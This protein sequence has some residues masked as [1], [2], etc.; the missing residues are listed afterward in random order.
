MKRA[1]PHVVS[2][3]LLLTGIAACDRNSNN[4]DQA[5]GT[6]APPT[7][8]T[9]TEE[10]SSGAPDTTANTGGIS[11]P[12][13]PVHDDLTVP[14]ARRGALSASGADVC[15]QWNL[16]GDTLARCRKEW[17]DAQGDAERLRIR[18]TYEP[19]AGAKDAQEIPV[20]RQ[21]EDLNNPTF[22]DQFKLKDSDRSECRAQWKAAKTEGDLARIRSRYETL[23]TN[24][25][26]N[27]SSNR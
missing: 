13:A 10:T 16:E 25:R 21:A 4:R 22:C 11:E 3:I 9:K 27:T 7:A 14:A 1:L 2:I 17:M 12:A 26:S 24:S 15:G 8:P 19:R 23:G 18:N 6:S 5:N 20:K